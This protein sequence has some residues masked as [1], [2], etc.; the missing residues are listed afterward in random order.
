MDSCWCPTG[1]FLARRLRTIGHAYTS[2]RALAFRALHRR[3]LDRMGMG[4]G[5]GFALPA[6]R[7]R[8]Q[9]LP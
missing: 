5:M 8:Q 4:M 1:S 9:A 3:V 6:Q 7:R 2:L